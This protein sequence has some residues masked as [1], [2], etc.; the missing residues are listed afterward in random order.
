MT[1][2]VINPFF[3]G[4]LHFWQ[5][6]LITRGYRK[7]VDTD[8]MNR[9]MRDRWNA[10]VPPRAFVYFLGDLSWSW[11]R[12]SMDIIKELNGLVIW[13]PGN[14]DRGREKHAAKELGWRVADSLHEI[15]VEDAEHPEGKQRITLCHYPLLTWNKAHHGAWALHGHSHGNAR[16]PMVCPI[17]DVGTDTNNFTPYSYAEVKAKIGHIKYT[18]MDHHKE[19]TGQ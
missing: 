5:D 3:T 15:D 7:F 14:H 16:Y 19:R 10:K 1:E 17:M 8:E 6:S 18:P 4:D 11:K 2:A 12:S 9:T 13:I